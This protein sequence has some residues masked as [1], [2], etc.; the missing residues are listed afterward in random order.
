MD[1]NTKK[2]SEFW[3]NNPILAGVPSPEEQTIEVSRMTMICTLA[4]A[5]EVAQLRASLH[6]DLDNIKDELQYLRR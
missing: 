4:L 1:E 6:K 2:R 3:N 5:F